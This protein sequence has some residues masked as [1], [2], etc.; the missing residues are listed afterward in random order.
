MGKKSGRTD[1]V[2]S[3]APKEQR[4]RAV[5]T[6][7]HMKTGPQSSG[8]EGRLTEKMAAESSEMEVIENA[9][10]KADIH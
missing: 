2:S 10:A 9:A 5:F 7:F 3:Q 1:P 6:Y 8:H 4:S